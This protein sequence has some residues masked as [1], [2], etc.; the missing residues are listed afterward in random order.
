MSNI[1]IALFVYKRLWHTQQT[2]RSLQENALAA[3]SDLYIFSDA[4]R[5]EAAEKEVSQVR[6]WIKTIS[7]F[8]QCHLILR[9]KNLGLANSIIQGVSSIL[10]ISNNIIVLEDDLVLSPFFL[11]YMHQG[12]ALY[13]DDPQVASIHGYALPIK[14]TMPETYFLRGADCWG[15]AT[16]KR[17]W[18]KFEADGSVLL[19]QLKAQK[20]NKEFNFQGTQANTQ[21]LQDQITGKNNSW[22]IRWHASA[23]LHNMMTL[24]PGRSL[25]RN[26]GMDNSGEHCGF[27]KE[28]DTE[29]TKQPIA[30]HPLLVTQSALAYDAYVMHYKSLKRSWM[31][32]I[33]G[34]V[35]RLLRLNAGHATKRQVIAEKL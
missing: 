21:M 1:P 7:G 8:R 10:S 6:A 33:K 27:S 19:K 12:L 5:D 23:F 24:Y 30:I 22:A 34:R 32:K 3:Q 2:I 20:L 28:W 26:I 16:W 15:W 4:P 11:E 17:A 35:R 18:D 13:Q 14:Q 31:D 25:V 9:E 29:L